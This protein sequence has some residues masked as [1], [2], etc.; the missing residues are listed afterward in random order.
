MLLL[1][2]VACVLHKNIHNLTANENVF[3]KVVM[4]MTSLTRLS[5]IRYANRLLLKFVNV[6]DVMSDWPLI[7]L[8]GQF[9]MIIHS[10]LHLNII[11]L[12]VNISHQH[13]CKPT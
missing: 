10:H 5:K 2:K 7:W 4:H 6:F 1:L 11:V 12:N 9:E 3:V 13:I 8:N